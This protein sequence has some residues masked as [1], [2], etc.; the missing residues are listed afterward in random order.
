[1]SNAHPYLELGDRRPEVI[2]AKSILASQ[3]FWTGDKSNYFDERFRNAVVA[4][5]GSHVGPDGKPLQAPGA[6]GPKTWWALYNPSG[7]AQRSHLVQVH[8]LETTLPNTAR[9]DY[10]TRLVQ[11]WKTGV[12][13]IPDGSNWG[14]G[15]STVLRNAGGPRPWCMHLV[16]HA[17]KLATG[18]YP[19]GADHGLVSA[20]WR[21]AKA[22]GLAHEK[23]SGYK[24]RPGD[25]GVTLYRSKSGKLN[26]TG[27]IWTAI[28]FEAGTSRYNHI[29]GNEGN[30]LKLG[31]RTTRDESL[32]G[33]ID[34]FND[35]AEPMRQLLPFQKDASKAAQ[36]FGKTR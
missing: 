11:L 21:E 12:Q 14:D 16:C 29:G 15:V 22:R 6:I 30:R 10:I 25:C 28:A 31:I 5:Q 36:D 13:E 2:I 4:F 33:W 9:A 32:F 18:H 24:P 8:S 26:G 1:M 3:G 19:F 34:L 7:E 17:H 27:H 23:G 35:G 20:F